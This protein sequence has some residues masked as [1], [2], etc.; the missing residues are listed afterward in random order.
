MRVF[1]V[2]AGVCVLGFVVAIAPGRLALAPAAA[3]AGQGLLVGVDDDGIEWTDNTS[4]AVK[5]ET[6]LGFGAVRLTIPWRP[7][8]IDAR[9]SY[10]ALQRAQQ[11]ARMGQH[12]ILD[13]YGPA[14]SPPITPAQQDSYCQYAVNALSRAPNVRDIV[15]WNEANSAT[16]WRPQAGAAAAYESLL[17]DCYDQLHTYRPTVNVISSTSPHENPGAFIA[18]LGQTYRDSGRNAPIFDTFGHNVY[19]EYSGESVFAQHPAASLSIDEGDYPRLM[20]ILNAAFLGTAQPVPG[21]GSVPTGGNLSPSVLA[22]LAPPRGRRTTTTTP[23]VIPGGPVTI[24]YLEDGFET[25]VPA[26]KR[27][28]YHGR[29]TNTRGVPALVKTAG[30]GPDQSSQFRDALELAYCQPAVGG[31]FNFE[32]TDDPAR[33]GWQS[34]IYWADGTLKPSAEYISGAIAYVAA[35]AVNCAS[36]PAAAT[37]LGGSSSGTTTASG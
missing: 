37:G 6:S 25:I 31:F 32:L 20:Q 8:W 30:D 9:G 26:A 11:A 27:A 7:G 10:L 16:F 1:L 17:A 13:I 12:V 35:N 19:P 18:Q 36:L 3:L 5:A 29:E 4:A 33:A 23:T 34:G 15:I 14:S 22:S 28:A 2:L 21:L 24:W